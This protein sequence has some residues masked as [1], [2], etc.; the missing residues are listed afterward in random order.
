MLAES[1]EALRLLGETAWFRGDVDSAEQWL[2]EALELA[3][4][5]GVSE[6]I[7]LSKCQLSY[8]ACARGDLKRAER[9]CEESLAGL[10]EHEDYISGVLQLALARVSLFRG[11]PTQALEQFQ[12]SLQYLRMWFSWGDTIS[13]L[14]S[15]SWALAALERYDGTAQLLGFLTTERERRG[16]VLPPVDRPHHERALFSAQETLGE[17]A[18]STAWEGG[19]ALTLKQAVELALAISP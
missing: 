6:G 19:A 12:H 11:D 7:I 13:A 1:C 10:Q 9:L 4:R 16:M 15:L 3:Q 8:I 17:G 18:F 2:T 5:G 14:E